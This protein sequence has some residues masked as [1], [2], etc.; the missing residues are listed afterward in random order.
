MWGSGGATVLCP[1][2]KTGWAEER[3]E[4]AVVRAG[5]L[6]TVACVVD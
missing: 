1:E 3:K 5:K 6:V 2:M 4:T